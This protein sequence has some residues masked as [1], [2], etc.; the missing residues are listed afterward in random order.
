M[1]LATVAQRFGILTSVVRWSNT[2]ASKEKRERPAIRINMAALQED[3]L[4]YPDAYQYERAKRLGVSKNCVWLALR[5]LNVT[6]KKTLVHP[7]SQPEKRS[8]FCQIIQHYQTEGRPIVS[9]DE[10]GFAHDMPRIRGYSPKGNRC[11]GKH[12]WGARGRTKVLQGLF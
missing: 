2:L 6:Y 8:A 5:R 12:D 11:Y 10:S 3:V 1:S 4:A 9:I 7:K